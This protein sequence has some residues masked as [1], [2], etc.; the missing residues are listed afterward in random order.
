MAHDTGTRSSS[1]PTTPSRRWTPLAL[2]TV[3]LLAV[4]V[5]GRVFRMLAALVSDG[6][7][8]FPS[9]MMLSVLSAVLIGGVGLTAGIRTIQHGERSW[10][11]WAGTVLSGLV[12]AFWVVFA[13]AEVVAPH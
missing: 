7:P 6:E 1:T 13:V 8:G 10:P 5:L 3:A 12:L 9:P 4:P 11:V 2:A